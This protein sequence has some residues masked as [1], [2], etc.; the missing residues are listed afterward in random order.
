MLKCTLNPIKQKPIIITSVLNTLSIGA[1]LITT[2]SWT[3]A[4]LPTIDIF[5]AGTMYTTCKVAVAVSVSTLYA[6]SLLGMD[7]T[8]GQGKI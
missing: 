1:S 2:P 6:S 4:I 5:F 3:G 7:R 8:S